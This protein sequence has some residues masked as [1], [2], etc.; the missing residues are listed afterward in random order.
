MKR[1]RQR[2]LVQDLFP[3]QVGQRHLR[4]RD[5]VV[6]VGGFEQFGLELR[7]V[8]RAIGRRLAHQKGHVDLLIAELLGV[9]VEHEAR[10]RPFQAG[11]DAG[12][13]DEARAGEPGGR[14][15]V[16]Q[17]ETFTELEVLL[18]LEAERRDLSMLSNLL[19]GA[20][21]LARGNL[22]RRDVGQAREQPVERLVQGAALGLG[23][24][25]FVA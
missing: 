2:R 21:V 18:G 12:K 24:L 9:Q 17:P 13:H 11:Q 14:L 20:L 16:H 5:Q 10:H 7:Q 22:V 4:R 25:G 8:A 1:T 15:E 6:A 3:H 19:G 23:I